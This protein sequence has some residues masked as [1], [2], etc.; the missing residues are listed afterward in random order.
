[1]MDLYDDLKTP[2]GTIQRLVAIL[3]VLQQ[4]GPALNLSAI[5]RNANLPISTTRRFLLQ[6]CDAQL[7]ERVGSH[8]QIGIGFFEIGM[9]APF[10]KRLRELARPFM[11]DLYKA[12]RQ[13]VHLGVLDDKGV[14]VIQQRSGR[15]SVRNPAQQDIRLAAHAT[16]NGKCLLAFSEPSKVER[17]LA[18]ELTSI[19]PN[20]ITSLDTLLKQLEEIRERGWSLAEQ[21]NSTGTISVATPVFRADGYA[22]A[23]LSL[24]VPA[25]TTNVKPYAHAVK[26]MA[27]TITRLWNQHQ[28]L[29]I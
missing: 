23:A 27:T 19:T 20:T 8:Y 29:P 5:A 17:I 25:T 11:E 12:T 28:S 10:P 24:V 26:T 13:N 1:M 9:K 21:E 2:H 7:L 16:A 3:T 14:L 15:E 18:Q 6:L 22:V 4:D